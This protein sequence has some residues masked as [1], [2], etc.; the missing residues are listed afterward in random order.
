MSGKTSDGTE[1]PN[2]MHKDDNPRPGSVGA[3]LGPRLKPDIPEVLDSSAGWMDKIM[4]FMGA[5]PTA[6]DGNN[7]ANWKG[8]NPDNT[9]QMDGFQQMADLYSRSQSP[10][11]P[12]INSTSN[13]ATGGTQVN[14]PIT[15]EGP[16]INLEVHGNVPDETIAKMMEAIEAGQDKTMAAVKLEMPEIASQTLRNALGAARSLQYDGQ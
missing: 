8:F 2:A 14:A 5:K 12:S 3:A 13:S 15:V 4:H 16:T 7:V 6:D 9:I 11:F 1:A 10:S